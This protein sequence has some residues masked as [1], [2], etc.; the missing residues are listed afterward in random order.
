LKYKDIFMRASSTQKNLALTFGAL[1]GWFAVALQLYLIIVNNSFSATEAL[2]RFFTFFT[3]LTN[4]LVALCLT[5]LFIRPGNGFFARS[6]TQAAIAAYITVVGVVYNIILRALWA[7]QGWQ[8]IVNELLHSVMPVYF[9][10]YWLV[11]SPK[12]GLQWKNILAWLVF[13]LAYLVLI[14]IR[15]ALSGWYPYPFVDVA[16]LGYAK[17]MVNSAGMMVFFL[18]VSAL[19]LAAGS[20]MGKRRG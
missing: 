8:L 9:I 6:G 19:F 1:L 20:A 7:P 12:T 16:T 4:M 3:I 14:M 2:A 10:I 17:V 5:I 13:P 11:F 15:G 18:L